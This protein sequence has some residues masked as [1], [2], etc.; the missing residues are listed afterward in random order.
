VT[1]TSTTPVPAG[2]VAVI[3]V[4]ELTVKLVAGVD[5]KSTA[6]APPNC[7]PV[8]FTEVP[9]A[10]LAVFGDTLVTIGPLV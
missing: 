5:P 6:L 2:D 4:G 7:R 9:P 10:G 8:M 1:V 3:D